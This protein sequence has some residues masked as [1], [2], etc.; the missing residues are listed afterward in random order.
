MWKNIPLILA[1]GRQRDICGWSLL[2]CGFFFPPVIPPVSPPS[3]DRKER[4]IE[5]ER[6]RDL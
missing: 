5:G 2:L 1:L 3:L 6:D 4:R